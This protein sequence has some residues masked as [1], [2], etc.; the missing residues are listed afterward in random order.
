MIRG[1][2][3]KPAGRVE[4]SGCRNEEMPWRLF[5]CIQAYLSKMR[6]LFG[7]HGIYGAWE[8]FTEL[9]GALSLKYGLDFSKHTGDN[10]GD[11]AT[12]KETCPALREGKVHR[13][14]VNKNAAWALAASIGHAFEEYDLFL[15]SRRTACE[16]AEV[17]GQ[18]AERKVGRR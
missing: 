17:V 13:V 18:R 4:D 5:A 6:T 14:A 1:A 16:V 10:G 12:L 8:Y 2:I 15:R 3:E 9:E 11:D 7:N